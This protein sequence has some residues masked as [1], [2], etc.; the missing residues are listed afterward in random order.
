M[1]EAKKCKRCGACQECGALR[2]VVY[3]FPVYPWGYPQPYT[4]PYRPYPYTTWINTGAV[5][6]GSYGAYS[7]TSAA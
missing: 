3:P 5:S 6:V 2:P 4:P 7:N 1:A